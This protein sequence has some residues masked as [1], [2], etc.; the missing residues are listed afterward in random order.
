MCGIV[1]AGH[2]SGLRIVGRVKRLTHRIPS[3]RRHWRLIDV[4]GV[5]LQ[6][7]LASIESV[8]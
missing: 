1:D 4:F 7:M 2:R 5:V 6:S 8:S 3:G